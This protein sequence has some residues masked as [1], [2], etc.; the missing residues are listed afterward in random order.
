MREENGPKQSVHRFLTSNHLSIIF[1]DVAYLLNRGYDKRKVID[2]V[3]SRYL[4]NWESRNFIFRTMSSDEH[5]NK[6]MIKLMTIDQ[7]KNKKLG[8]D[9][10]N[11]LI[12]LKEM[13]QGNPVFLCY[14]GVI[15]DICGNYG[16][17]L[18]DD[19][20]YKA[21]KLF[22]TVL[23]SFSLKKF[24]LFLDQPVSHS[25]KVAEC[26]RDE[27]RNTLIKQ[28]GSTKFSTSSI[29]NS[30]ITVR[31]PDH[32]LKQFDLV[33]SHDSIVMERPEGIFDIPHHIIRTKLLTPKVVDIRSIFV[34]F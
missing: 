33:A 8:L 6:I 3:A 11:I 9:G 25:G 1:Q 24:R 23:A 19:V 26:L 16:K 5:A 22:S 29:E 31:S 27:L 32:E 15:R 4:L 10:F 17:F 12:T 18:L 20:G 13:I 21:M 2:F 7:L 28:K 34:K 14:D 30:I